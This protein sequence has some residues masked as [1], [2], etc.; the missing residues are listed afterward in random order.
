MEIGDRTLQSIAKDIVAQVEMKRRR[1]LNVVFLPTRLADIRRDE[2]VGAVY[3]NRP[4]EG[5][6]E[7]ALFVLTRDFNCHYRYV[8]ED[9]ILFYAD[10]GYPKT[11]KVRRLPEISNGVQIP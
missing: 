2:T 3:G 4:I 11:R 5:Q 10:E 9:T 6:A 1:K 7:D 8:G